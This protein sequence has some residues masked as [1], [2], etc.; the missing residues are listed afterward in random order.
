MVEKVGKETLKVQT[1]GPDGKFGKTLTLKITGTSKITTLSQRQQAG[2]AVLVQRDAD[3]K[4]LQPNQP[5]T[6][7]YAKGASGEV[8]LSAVVQPAAGK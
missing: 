5:I 3:A 6:V 2:K 8:L 1:R 4:D 7:I